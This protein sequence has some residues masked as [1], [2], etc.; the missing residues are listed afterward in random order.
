MRVMDFRTQGRRCGESGLPN[1]EGAK[2]RQKS[3]KD[4]H[5]GFRFFCVF[6]VAFAPSAFGCWFFPKSELAR[7]NGKSAFFSVRSTKE[8][9]LWRMP[10][11]L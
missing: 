11:I 1:A 2:V 7:Y 10:L 9:L 6:C 5:E 8:D 3:Q 4:I